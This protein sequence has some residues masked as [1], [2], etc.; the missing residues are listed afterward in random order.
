MNHRG[1][2]A[3]LDRSEPQVQVGGGDHGIAPGEKDYILISA[4][5]QPGWVHLY[6]LSREG[7]DLSPIERF[8]LLQCGS[9]QPGGI[10]LGVD[11]VCGADRLQAFERYISFIIKPETNKVE[12]GYSWGRRFKKLPLEAVRQIYIPSL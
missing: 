11:A 10:E 6:L 5:L 12:P 1:L 8:H 7:M 9:H 2:N 4:F 3:H